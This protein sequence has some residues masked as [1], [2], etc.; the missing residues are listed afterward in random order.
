MSVHSSVAAIK[1]GP[2]HKSMETA[3]VSQA[4]LETTVKQVR[5]NKIIKLRIF[6]IHIIRV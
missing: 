5:N 2:V 6:K 1:G 3:T 4:G